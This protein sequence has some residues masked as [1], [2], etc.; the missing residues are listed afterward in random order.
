MVIFTQALKSCN[1]VFWSVRGG[2]ALNYGIVLAWQIKLV[3]VPGTVTVSNVKRKIEQNAT[4]LVH[5]YQTFAPSTNRNLFHRAQISPEN[6]NTD[7]RKKTVAVYFQTLYLGKAS[8]VEKIMQNSFPELG[9]VNQDCLEISWAKSALWFAGDVGF[10]KGDSL[11][12]LLNRGLAP[13]QY[14]KAKSDYIEEPTSIKGLEQIWLRLMEME[15]G[16]TNL[17]MIPYAGKMSTILEGVIPFPHRAGH[18]YML[19]QEVYWN[20]NT[21]VDF[22]NKRLS[23]LRSLSNDLSPYVSSNPRRSYINYNDLDLG[24]GNSSYEEA[25]T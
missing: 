19:L 8:G 23:W 22:Q 5:K 4:N 1:D 20:G 16:A 15:Q 24:V 6:L 3:P 21:P 9:L 18:L 11:Q 2:I 7:G 10:P 13:E 12:Q 14:I 17:V 25:S